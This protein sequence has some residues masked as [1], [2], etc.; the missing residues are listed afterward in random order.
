MLPI[1][2]VA[3]LAFAAAPLRLQQQPS[4]VRMSDTDDMQPDPAFAS[5]E[6]SRTWERAGKGK[7]RWAPGD[8]TGDAVLDTRLLYS[9]WVLNPM[10][11]HVR[12]GCCQSL[13]CQLV[14]NWLKLPFKVEVHASTTGDALPSADGALLPRLE[15]K[16]VPEGLDTFGKITSFA[17]AVAKPG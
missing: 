11:L 3:V 17:S 14:L 5:E 15:G 6:L 1:T 8:V 4:S 13:G 12:E 16:G 2:A 10:C 7:K 9:T